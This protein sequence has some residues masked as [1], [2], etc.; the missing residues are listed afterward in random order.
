MK[1]AMSNPEDAFI[2]KINEHLYSNSQYRFNS[3]GD[4][5]HI[6]DLEYADLLAFH[7]KYYHPSSQ[8]GLPLNRSTRKSTSRLSLAAKWRLWG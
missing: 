6:P 7:K 5:K 2:H 1:G 8:A 3:G 4:P